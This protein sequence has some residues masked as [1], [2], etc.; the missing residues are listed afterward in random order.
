MKALLQR[1]DKA[2]VS[3]DG[4]VTGEIDKGLCVFLVSSMR[5]QKKT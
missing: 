4:N 2:A 5:I 1:V 3:V